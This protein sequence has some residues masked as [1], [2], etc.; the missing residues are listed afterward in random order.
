VIQEFKNLLKK[1]DV[2]D[3]IELKA[4]FCFNECINGVNVKCETGSMM[5]QEMP[6]MTLCDDGFLLHHVT[7]EN[8]EDLFVK[9]IYPLLNL[10]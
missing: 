3:L 2:E 6:N 8:A 5:N 9:Q 7:K 1:Y 4:S 10:K